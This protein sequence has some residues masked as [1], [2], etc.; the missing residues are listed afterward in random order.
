MNQTRGLSNYIPRVLLDKTKAHHAGHKYRSIYC[1]G[2]PIHMTELAR[3]FAGQVRHSRGDRAIDI[4]AELRSDG[5][6][7]L[8]VARVPGIGRLQAA[9]EQQPRLFARTPR[10]A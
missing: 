10:A 3:K 6:P 2:I 5:E 4:R 9:R 8:I 1:L 7:K